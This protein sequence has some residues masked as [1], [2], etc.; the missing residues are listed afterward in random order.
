VVVDVIQPHLF[1]AK[2]CVPA[3]IDILIAFLHPVHSTHKQLKLDTQFLYNRPLFPQVLKHDLEL[4]LAAAEQFEWPSLSDARESAHTITARKG[5]KSKKCLGNFLSKY[6]SYLTDVNIPGLVLQN[7]SLT[8]R[9]RKCIV[10]A[11]PYPRMK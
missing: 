9:E 3:L 10:C 11:H 1:S 6:T 4:V 7:A 5:M 8:N 2:H